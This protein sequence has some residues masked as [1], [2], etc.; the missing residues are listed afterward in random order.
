MTDIVTRFEALK[1]KNYYH[2]LVGLFI[3]YF[4]YMK[5]WQK[6][7]MEHYLFVLN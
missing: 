7:K 1:N 6:M 4:I 3:M 2:I 5:K